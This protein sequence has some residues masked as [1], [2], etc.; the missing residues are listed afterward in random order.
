MI[1][2]FTVIIVNIELD[3]SKHAHQSM[4]YLCLYNALSY[5]HVDVTIANTYF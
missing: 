3:A 1:N 4:L 5:V 2:Q